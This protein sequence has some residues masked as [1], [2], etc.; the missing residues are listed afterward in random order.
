[1]WKQFKSLS[2][3]LSHYEINN[4]DPRKCLKWNKGPFRIHSRFSPAVPVLPDLQIKVCTH[5]CYG[6][7]TFGPTGALFLILL[8]STKGRVWSFH[9][10]AV[11]AFIPLM[12]F[13]WFAAGKTFNWPEGEQMHS[14]YRLDVMPSITWFSGCFLG[15]GQSNYLAFWS[16]TL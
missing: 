7:P 4:T 5:S 13:Y 6:R 1:M 10:L 16:P 14:C 11:L 8:R 2:F 15:Q 9:I 3:Y 12:T